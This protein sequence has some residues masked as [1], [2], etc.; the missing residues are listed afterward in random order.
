M[1]LFCSYAFTGEDVSA[2]TRRMQL[3]VD[4]LTAAGYDVYCPLFDPYKNELQQKNDTKAIFEYAFQNIGKCDGIVAIVT[5][6]RRSEGQ[7]LEI[8]AMLVA[9]KPLF[10]LLHASAAAAPSHLPKLATKSFTWTSEDEL[11]ACLS[12]L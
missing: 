5:S 3:A 8:G 7:L 1:K 11:V 10:L 9:D 6:D 12:E 2:V 4:A